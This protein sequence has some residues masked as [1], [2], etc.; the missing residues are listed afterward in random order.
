MQEYLSGSRSKSQKAENGV[1]SFRD[2]RLTAPSA[3]TFPSVFEQLGLTPAPV[4]A[5]GAYENGLFSVVDAETGRDL[6]ESW[7]WLL[8]DNWI[9]FLT[10]GF[11]DVFFL[12]DDEVR[13]LDVQRAHVEF[14]DREVTWCLDNFLA[15]AGVLTKVLRKPLLD[16]LVRRLRPLEYHEAF[17]LKP[18]RLLGGEDRPENY[19]IGHCGVYVDLVGQTIPQLT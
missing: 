8:G 17:I 7:E 18:W 13:W 10:T 1:A 15:D 14:I 5:V 3:S 11:G 12:A 19:E 16:E 2:F 4:P 9:A 6:L